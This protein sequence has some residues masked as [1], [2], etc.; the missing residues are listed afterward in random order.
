MQTSLKL[1]AAGHL[2][3]KRIIWM[4]DSAYNDESFLVKMRFHLNGRLVININ[5]LKPGVL[6]HLVSPDPPQLTILELLNINLPLST[7]VKSVNFLVI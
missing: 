1:T 6:I 3:P 2:L 4:R 5:R 7:S